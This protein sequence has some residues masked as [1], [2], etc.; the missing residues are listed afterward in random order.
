MTLLL[1]L[2]LPSGGVITLLIFK[3]FVEPKS[4][5]PA[6]LIKGGEVEVD[7]VPNTFL[8]LLLSLS[9]P[10]GFLIGDMLG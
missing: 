7:C 6:L 4:E 8:L 10:I 3:S 5:E 2:L 9:A 1:L